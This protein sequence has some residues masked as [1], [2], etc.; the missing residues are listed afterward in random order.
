MTSGS[1]NNVSGRRI[2]FSRVGMKEEFCRNQ[3]SSSRIECVCLDREFRVERCFCGIG[4][5]VNGNK[6]ATFSGN[7]FSL[8]E[9]PMTASRPSRPLNASIKRDDAGFRIQSFLGLLICRVESFSNSSDCELCN[10]PLRVTSTEMCVTGAGND[11][12]STPLT[13]KRVKWSTSKVGANKPTWKVSGGRSERA[14]RQEMRN[15]PRCLG[16]NPA[17]TFSINRRIRS[18]RIL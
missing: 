6:V 2:G 4:F 11:F 8:I 10:G 3:R 18:A 17:L 7:G 13:N 14:R 16:A 12:A 1:V 5:P 15:A 9:T